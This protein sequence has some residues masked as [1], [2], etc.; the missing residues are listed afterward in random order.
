MEYDKTQQ[1]TKNTDSGW[2]YD[3]LFYLLKRT[4]AIL[5]RRPPFESSRRCDWF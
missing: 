2:W 5:T 4:I 1:S 3:L